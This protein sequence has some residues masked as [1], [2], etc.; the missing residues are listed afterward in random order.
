M[1]A[2]AG[3]TV[4]DFSRFLPGAY[5]GWLAG[6]M[7][8]E[9]IRIEHPREL[10]KAQA[11]FGS[12]A[13]EQAE[14]LRRARPSYTRNK[15]S[16]LLNPGHP[17]AAPVLHALVKRA[18]VLVED[19]RPGV[20][21]AMGLGYADLAAINPR[22]IYASVSFTGQTGPLAGRAGHDPAALALAGA[23]S[24]L[25]GTPEPT[26]PGA[27]V[28][29][30]LAGAH[31]SIA[32]L[33]ALQSR[34]ASGAGQHVDVA[35]TDAAMPLLMVALGRAQDPTEIG[36]PSGD[37]HPKGGVWRCADGEWLCTTDMEPRYWARFCEAMERPDYAARQFDLAA[38]PAMHEDLA[39]LFAS[40][41][42][43]HWLA[44]LEAADTQVMP[45]LTPGQ[46]LRHPHAKARGMHVTLP[47]GD[48]AALG[49][50]ET[51]EQVGTPFRLSACP[52]VQHRPAP[53]PG[54]D[55]A[56]ILAELGFDAEALEAAGV[57]SSRQGASR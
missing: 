44:L 6:D 21:A 45:V 40:R 51:V 5:F 27:Q 20:M 10:A 1:T 14:R 15:R 35:M 3:L 22:L 53:L 55:N 19:Y 9:V 26:L 23:L 37:W 30:V 50:K 32:V 13:D 2:L 49:E 42:R 28:A 33:T 17:E 4:L 46:A 39:A 54:A 36:F 11:M 31:A 25:N 43:A 52:P 18:D 8:A 41:D 34:N 12:G 38:H 7:G 29:D 48:E 57:F 16:L 24:R 47:I 56:A